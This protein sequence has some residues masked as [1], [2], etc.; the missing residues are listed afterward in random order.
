MKNLLSILI[1]ILFI[2]GLL[3]ISSA[4][5]YK[6]GVHAPLT[7]PAAE[8]GQYIKNGAL[9]AVDDINNKG[10]V[11]GKKI[12]VVFGD[13]EA[14]PEVGVSVYERFMTKDKVDAVIGGLNSSVNIAMQETAAKYDKIFITGGPVSEILTE[15]VEKDPNKYWMYFKT[16]PAYSKMKPSYKSFFKLLET[17]GLLKPKNKTFA[18]I[19]EDTDYGR[20]VAMSFQEAMKEEGW[21]IIANEVVKIDQADFSAQMSKLRALKPD[22]LFTCQVSP[23]AA[24]S[25]CKAF[26]QSAI[27]SFFLAIY[28]PSNPEYVKLTGEASNT[29]VWASSIDFVPKFAKRFLEEY[30]LR[31]KGEPGQNAGIQYDAMMNF[32]AAAKLANSLE[33]KAVADAMTKIKNEG[34][35]GIFQSVVS[36]M[37]PSQGTIMCRFGSSK[38]SNGKHYAIY[39]ERYRDRD[40]VKQKWMK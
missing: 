13:D 8:V 39:P 28:T 33:P 27:P 11:L 38:S 3:S 1:S 20:G 37:K 34:T 10:G 21:K 35:M 19:V 15:R 25:L 6:I 12:E 7:G 22:V 4:D 30:A 32:V 24:A 29:L 18:T 26:Y 5:N 17:K 16:S 36:H 23:A 40:Y 2:F 9:L 14:K 31:Y